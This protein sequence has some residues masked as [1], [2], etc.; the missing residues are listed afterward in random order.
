MNG[1]NEETIGDELRLNRIK[2]GLSLYKIS[3]LVGVSENYLSMIER[4][5]R[6]KVADDILLNIAEAYGMDPTY[7]FKKFNKIPPTLLE[8]LNRYKALDETLLKISLD[9]KLSETQ[10]EKLYDQFKNL[11]DEAV[12]IDE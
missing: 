7:L 5:V 4:G 3:D 6:K 2:M 9:G 12:G 1:L 8:D 11:Y 10:K